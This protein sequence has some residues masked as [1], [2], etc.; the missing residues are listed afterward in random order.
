MI[1][2][3]PTFIELAGDGASY[4]KFLPSLDGISLTPTFEGKKLEREKPLFFQYGGWNVVRENQWKLVQRKQEDWHLYNLDRD[5][6]E[7]INLAD[8]FPDRVTQMIRAWQ[9]WANEVGIG[10]EKAKKGN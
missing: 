4:P 6:T 8:Q 1:D 5:R 9:N 3:V 10:S 7:T 2:L